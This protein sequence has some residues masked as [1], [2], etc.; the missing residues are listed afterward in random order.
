MKLLN[1]GNN[2]SHVLKWAK[3]RVLKLDNLESG[4]YHPG[5]ADTLEV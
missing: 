1:T 2:N 5:A 3:T 4:N